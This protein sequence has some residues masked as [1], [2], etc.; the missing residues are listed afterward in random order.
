MGRFEESMEIGRNAEQR[1]AATLTNPKFPTDEEDINEHWDVMDSMGYR[2]DVK[3]MKKYRRE[4]PEPTDR[5]HWVEL[6]NVNGKLGWLYGKAYYIAFETRN[7]WIVVR[8]EDL[9]KFIEGVLDG[10]EITTLKPMP[11]EIYQREGRQDLLT[12]IPTVDLLAIA[13]RVDCKQ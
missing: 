11:Y 2:Y 3:A 1:F 5:L 12:I 10:W 13:E 4:D 9:V 6:R 8:R 7:W